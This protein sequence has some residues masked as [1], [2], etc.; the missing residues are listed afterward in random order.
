MS[1]IT[2]LAYGLGGTLGVISAFL[3]LYISYRLVI[4][5]YKKLVRKHF[6][7]AMMETYKKM[8][9]KNEK[10]EELSEF[11]KLIENFDNKKAK[12]RLKNKYYV[13]VDVFIGW[14]TERNHY[15]RFTLRFQKYITKKKK[16]INK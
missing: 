14:I 3:L 12:D 16:A 7:I 5:A 2:G 11:C 10:F 13:K 8:L 6:T 1:I 4:F 15:Q 9:L